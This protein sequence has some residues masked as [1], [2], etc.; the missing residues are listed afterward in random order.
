M[1]LAVA[2][3]AVALPSC[4]GKKKDAKAAELTLADETKGQLE[5]MY[6]ACMKYSNSEST[7]DGALVVE[8]FK[9]YKN[10]TFKIMDESKEKAAERHAAE[11][12]WAKANKEKAEVLNNMSRGVGNC[13]YIGYK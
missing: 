8:M 1:I 4:G 2:A 12:E 9:A 3:I 11:M 5:D 13:L 10:I 7:E 6:D